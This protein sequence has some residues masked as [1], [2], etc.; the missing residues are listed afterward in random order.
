LTTKSVN[1]DKHCRS[2]DWVSLTKTFRE[3]IEVS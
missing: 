3:A 2:I 1:R